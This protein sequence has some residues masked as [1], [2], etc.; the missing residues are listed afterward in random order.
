MTCEHELWACAAH[1]LGQ[2]G[3][4]A[5]AFVADRVAA[6]ARAGDAAGVKTWLVIASRMDALRD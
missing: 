3:E 1:V 6:L 4:E 5:I 2:H